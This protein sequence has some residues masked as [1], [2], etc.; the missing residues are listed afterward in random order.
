MPQPAVG[1]GDVLEVVFCL[2]PTRELSEVFRTCS[3][4]RFGWWC[5]QD[6]VVLLSSP[7][8]ASQT[9]RQLTKRDV[10]VNK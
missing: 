7:G 3:E 5:E 1:I 2:V 6:A 4:M 8:P 10:F 9:L